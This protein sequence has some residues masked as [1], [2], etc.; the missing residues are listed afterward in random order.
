MIFVIFPGE[1]RRMQRQRWAVTAVQERASERVCTGERERER[2]RDKERERE[3]VGGGQ[4]KKREK[5]R[6]RSSR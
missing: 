6:E 1:R 5:E 3:C 4:E 2:A